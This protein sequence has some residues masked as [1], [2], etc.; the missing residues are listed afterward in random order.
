M[1][2]NEEGLSI[3]IKVWA[4]CDNDPLLAFKMEKEAK[5]PE[6]QAGEGFLP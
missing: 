2:E 4:R 5:C 3:G 1:Q 6:I